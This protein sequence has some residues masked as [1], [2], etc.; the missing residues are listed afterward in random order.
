MLNN[1]CVLTESRAKFRPVKICSSPLVA[2]AAVRLKEMIVLLL[3]HYFLLLS[4]YVG[5]LLCLVFVL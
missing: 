2:S 1:I 3:I 5:G 4:L